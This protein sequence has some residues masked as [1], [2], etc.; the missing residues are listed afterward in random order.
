VVVTEPIPLALTNAQVPGYPSATA[1]TYAFDCGSGSYGVTGSSATASCP[2][3]IAGSRT[4][5]GKVVDQDGD[6][7]EYSATVTVK[8]APEATSDLRLSVTGVP[9][10]P[11]IRKALLSKLDAA[12]KA[13]AQGKINTACSSL[14]DFINQVKAQRGKAIPVAT[15]DEW[16]LMATRLRAALGC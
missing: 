16:I 2:T 1:F 5:R 14:G 3:S 12:L 15:A 13:I 11:D 7:T 6:K 9:L 4:V 10:A 8:S